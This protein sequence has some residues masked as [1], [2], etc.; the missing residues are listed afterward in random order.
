MESYGPY[1]QFATTDDGLLRRARRDFSIWLAASL[2]VSL[3]PF[4]LVALAYKAVYKT[5]TWPTVPMLFGRGDLLPVVLAVTGATMAELLLSPA[6]L[7]YPPKAVGAALS[8]FIS[9][10]AGVVFVVIAYSAL[11]HDKVSSP[12]AAFTATL[13]IVLL[14]FVV[15]IHAMTLLWRPEDH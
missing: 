15:L 6:N 13:S 8:L 3:L 1:D 11:A 5:H 14:T 7:G 10:A 4:L 2:S 12:D 9:A